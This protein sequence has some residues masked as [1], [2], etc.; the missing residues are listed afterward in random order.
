[1]PRTSSNSMTDSLELF[2]PLIQ[3]WFKNAYSLPTDVQQK[4]WRAISNSEHVLVSAPTG[5]G[6]TLA[7][8]LWALNQLITE[9]WN[10]GS[11]QVLYISPLKALNTDIRENLLKP[12]FEI[13]KQFSINDQS[14]PLIRIKTRSGDTPLN[15]RRSIVK[16]PPE[17]LITTPEGLNIILSSPRARTILKNLKTVILDEIH[18]VASDKRGALLSTSIE[19]LVLLSG[20]FQRIALS[21]TVKPLDM[22]AKFTGG[23]FL[24]R[25]SDTISYKPRPVTI[26]TS[27]FKK[28][29]QLQIENLQP[30]F[31]GTANKDSF[32]IL[33]AE[34]LISIMQRNRTTLIFVNN[35]RFSERIVMYI[36]DMTDKQYVYSHHG[37]LSRELRH[38]VERRL[39][40]GLLKAIVATS[41]LEM[42][43]DIGE[44][45][46]VVLVGTPSTV[47]S[48]LQRIGRAGH[49]VHKIS[50]CTFIPT[51][52]LDLLYATVVCK[53]VKDRDI[54]AIHLIENPLDILAQVLLSISGTD[55]FSADDLYEFIRTSA[56]F[57]TLPRRQFDLVIMMLTGKYGETRI[58]ELHPRILIDDAKNRIK[59]K[60]GMLCLIYKN[61]GTIPD[62]GYFNLRIINTQAKIGELDEEFV[63]ERRIGDT[64]LMGAQH[65]RIESIDD[66]NVEV[67]L[68]H[69]RASMSPFWKAD[70]PNKS[71]HIARK[72]SEF[73]EQWN[74]FT[75]DSS[76]TDVLQ[77]EYS[78]D[79]AAAAS[80]CS[81]LEYQKIHTGRILPHRHHII[82]EHVKETDSEN[83]PHTI[84]HTLWGNAVNYPFMLALS[85][86][87]EERYKRRLVSFT[88]N[89]ALFIQEII[90]AEDITSL[91]NAKRLEN[92]LRKSLE[93][94]TFFGARFRENSGRALLLPRSDPRRRIP[95]WITRQRS[96]KLFNSIRKYSDFPMTIET[97]RTCL[98]DEFDLFALSNLIKEISS[99]EIKISSVES[100]VPSPFSGTLQYQFTNK[101]LYEDDT[102]HRSSSDTSLSQD[103]LDEITRS[104]ALRPAFARNDVTSLQQKLHRTA[105]GYNPGNPDE[106][107]EWLDERICIPIDEWQFLLNAIIN[108]LNF[109]KDK[110]PELIKIETL[111][112]KLPNAAT[113]C[114]VTFKNAAILCRVFEIK[115]ENIIQLA[116]NNAD[117]VLQISK[118]IKTAIAESDEE[119]LFDCTSLISQWLTFYAP[120]K[121]EF[122]SQVFGFE[123]EAII[124]LIENLVNQKTIITNITIKNEGSDFICDCDNCE[125]LLHLIQKS[126]KSGFKPLPIENLQLFIAQVQGITQKKSGKEGL[127]SA[128]DKLFNYPLKAALWEND[129]F[130][131]R[132]SNYQTNYL[133]SLLS[134]TNLEWYGCGRVQ[135]SFRLFEDRELC[136]YNPGVSKEEIG[137]EDYNARYSYSDLLNKS[138]VDSSSF[139]SVFW[140]AVW[141]G[142]LNSDTYESIRKGIALQFGKENEVPSTKQL[143]PEI[144]S[145]HRKR[146]IS[147]NKW[148]TTRLLPGNWKIISVPESE[149]DPVYQNDLCKD[150]IRILLSRY[151]IIFRELLTNELP[152]FQWPQIFKT[153]RIMELSGEVLTGHFF[154]TIPGLQF[155]SHEAFKSLQNTLDENIIYWINAADPAS[156]CGVNIQKLKTHLPERLSTTHLFYHGKHLVIISRK[157][158][159]ELECK[160]TPDSKSAIEYC[161]KV[162]ELAERKVYNINQLKIELINNESIY[163]SPYTPIFTAAGFTK[164][165]RYLS[166]WPD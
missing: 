97:W 60:D 120:V 43:I 51:N 49:S 109:S 91:V 84:I 87:W 157:K 121:I 57:I 99:G 78:L 122:L 127:Q 119:W 93:Q 19:R 52:G 27:D 77:T 140:K 61:G 71:Y 79:T 110:I 148:K 133:D 64:F 162:K 31:N 3:N 112:V 55:S 9:K 104:P 14:M 33:L 92:L 12:L 81:Y 137:F 17:I 46:E 107:I 116:D 141:T 68:W 90:T 159:K 36:N 146:P 73:L 134:A 75:K 54:E 155:I 158:G 13:R 15:E 131:A 69:G 152:G 45:D 83:E 37:S 22:T 42:G 144:D 106:L 145:F 41:S 117:T 114:I 58:R 70:T 129:V 153:L 7:A 154:D 165:Y 34:R 40:A 8:F 26:I 124:R 5:T 150:R 149:D 126:S 138:N 156:L 85:A 123:K 16:H 4:A 25:N 38:E 88:S 59:A 50:R 89:E 66:Q 65:W 28:Q 136:S 143:I 139:S 151:G 53:M 47:S 32:W 108:D 6:K 163:N 63:W 161:S 132:I 96:K 113:E 72:A 86:A 105:E 44:I 56:T 147:F 2:H 21:A 115:P 82:I 39:K 24:V 103:L 67:S 1:M 62:R 95:F 10:T 164:D 80:L 74:D 166:Y 128:L 125:R 76:F 35:R 102:P 142:F 98:Q 100:S 48:S 18:A 111:I 118:L 30:A 130:P 94:S 160:F 29:Y 20:E 101:Y 11:V 135:L 23:Y